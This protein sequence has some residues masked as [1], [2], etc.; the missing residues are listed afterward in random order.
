M[1]RAKQLE[2]A[3]EDILRLYGFVYLR[4]DNYR[5]FRCGQVQNSKASGFPDFFVYHP[6]VFAVECKTGQG[7]LSKDQKYVRKCMEA[8]GIKYLLVHD[9]VDTLLE[10]LS[11][12]KKF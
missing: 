1:S 9:N 10:Y 3:V 6:A 11:D 7:K 4:I 5:C 2:N 8:T 12:E